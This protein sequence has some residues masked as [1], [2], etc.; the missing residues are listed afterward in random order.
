MSGK[1]FKGLKKKNSSKNGTSE[2]II[3]IVKILSMIDAGEKVTAV[4]L[5]EILEKS[6]R[7]IGRYIQTIEESGIPIYYDR[8][9]KTY[10]FD[11]TFSLKKI[12]FNPD[13]FSNFMSVR[14]LVTNL[15][16][17]SDSPFFTVVERIAQN[18]GINS[19]DKNF[20]IIVNLGITLQS[21]ETEKVLSII[22][23]AISSKC[24]VWIKYYA[25]SS[26][27]ETERE[28]A[29]YGLT[30]SDGFWYMV[31]KCDL[32]GAMRTFAIDG[33]KEIKNT[34][35]RYAI[36]RNFNLADYFSKS[37]KIVVDNDV[38]VK[39]RFSCKVAHQILRKKWHRFQEA[40]QMQN[41]DVVLFFKVA[42]TEEIKRWIYS[43]I[44]DC[45][46]ISPP[47][48]RKEIRAELQKTLK[49]YS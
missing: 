44:P 10:A 32:R 28:V 46:V 33:I 22:N 41:G 12:I 37:F 25:N 9:E 4:K 40:K 43:W 8:E 49:K 13:E 34:N 5:S 48:L 6:T 1:K 24:R 16:F 35:N 42:G 45:E 20:P 31:G 18:A 30:Y 17:P 23:S 7:S 11:G 36:P 14:E 27:K 39:I 29:P 19:S 3:N 21:P 15:G 2:K 26:Q 47:E 38:E